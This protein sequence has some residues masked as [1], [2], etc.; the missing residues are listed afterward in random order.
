MKVGVDDSKQFEKDKDDKDKD[1]E[2][3]NESDDEKEDLGNPVV[4]MVYEF[5]TEPEST[6]YAVIY[7][8]FIS[9]I[10]VVRVLFIGLETCDG[11][12]QYIDR[13]DHKH[14][15]YYFLLD[16][17]QYWTA[18]VVFMVPIIC[19]AFARLVMIGYLFFAE[20]NLRLY[21]KFLNNRFSFFLYICDI[22]CVLPFFI[23]AVYVKPLN[24]VLSDGS[25][26][27]L[28]ILE[29]LGTS[30]IFRM[31]KDIPAIWA[32]RIALSR[33][34]PHLV[35]P[36]F[37]FFAFNISAGVLLYYLEPCYNTA[38]CSSGWKTLIDSTFYSIVSMTTTGYGN[39]TPAFIHGRF[40]ACIIM[41]FGS[42]FMSMPLAI[43]GNEYQDAWSEVNVKIRKKADLRA[44]RLKIAASALVSRRPHHGHRNSK[45]AD[46]SSS[47]LLSADEKEKEEEKKLLSDSQLISSYHNLENSLNTLIKELNK[48]C[49]QNT[50]LALHGKTVSSTV[51]TSRMSP[52]VL[53]HFLQFRANIPPFLGC[54]R[55]AMSFVSNTEKALSQPAQRLSLMRRFSSIGNQGVKVANTVVDKAASAVN[56]LSRGTMIAPSNTNETPTHKHSMFG[57]SNKDIEASEQ[58]NLSSKSS[59]K[60]VGSIMVHMRSAMLVSNRSVKGMLGAL[61]FSEEEAR[62][63]GDS[64]EFAIMM[65]R[66]M[67]R[68]NSYKSRIWKLLEAPHSSNEARFLQVFLLF[69]ICASIFVLYT[70]TMT[71]L[72]Y[73]GEDASLCGQVMQFY[74]QDK[75][76]PAQDPGCFVM[77]PDGVIM[78][79]QLEFGPG[80]NHADCFAKGNNFGT[81]N[82]NLTCSNTL[83][84]PF[85]TSQ[86]L[87]YSYGAPY[88]YTVRPE[89]HRITPICNRLECT[90]SE[91]VV[92][93]NS[94]WL[95]AE[96][97]TNSVFTVEVFLRI[98]VSSSFVGY[99]RDKINILDLLSILPFYV[100][101]FDAAI[102]KG[103]SNLD[104][105]ILSSSPQRLVLVA[106]RSFKIFRLFKLTRHFRASKEL[107]ETA[108][109]VAKQ[110]L[111]MV[112]LLIFFVIIFAI[113]L[114]EVEG[115]RACFVGDIDCVDKDNVVETLQAG[116]R[117]KINKLGKISQFSNMFYSL[118][119]SMVTLTTTGYGDVV[120]QTNAGQVMA[121]FLMLSGSMYMAMPLTA[122]AS[123]FYDVH[124]KYNQAAKRS[125]EKHRVKRDLDET[126][127]AKILNLQILLISAEVDINS[128]VNDMQQ[129][130]SV[131]GPGAGVGSVPGSGGA[132]TGTSTV[133]SPGVSKWNV[134]RAAKSELI[135]PGTGTSSTVRTAELT[136]TDEAGAAYCTTNTSAA[137]PDSELLRRVRKIATGV[138]AALPNYAVEVRKLAL[139]HAKK[140]KMLFEKMAADQH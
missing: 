123:T 126:A 129:P 43:I 77:G 2:N 64:S 139:L 85:Q 103:L 81:F 118:W 96:V 134:L 88:F 34:A 132:G 105:A 15:R 46:P 71:S 53:L 40:F 65:E 95:P 18:Y 138:K 93:G 68:P 104:F 119:F 99:L 50:A 100:E 135:N 102:G 60:G 42:L 13:A 128:F 58:T 66:A 69:L 16:E 112:C 120:P 26:V 3:E 79:R 36:L 52:M 87:L 101:I 82:P 59:S 92:D 33:S 51:K 17:D 89:I 25:R 94:F 14:A 107:G 78:D 83:H 113:M 140:Q 9:W 23:T 27:L 116:S 24:V 41:I 19:D 115:G 136:V 72:S 55:G 80:C 56:Q 12:N 91:N 106:L 61:G 90:D 62:L 21:N 47:A 133:R 31:S 124:Q 84:P 97:F 67:K 35:V 137:S 127:K 117:I 63:R 54:A 74:C 30:R 122:A 121:I 1:E 48:S 10:V 109:K 111:G 5:F 22:V 44:L 108:T 45:G 131:T 37:F 49:D 39:Q 73:Y 125:K 28:R 6:R 4:V 86:Q 20:E 130:A 70:E 32:I 7:I 98:A 75:Q 29:L 114:Y 11:P 110:I 8:I 57:Q 38:T 76:S